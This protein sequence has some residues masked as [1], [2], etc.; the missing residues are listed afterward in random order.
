MVSR[1][2]WCWISQEVIT[3]HSSSVD[4][5]A[6]EHDG[7]LENGAFKDAFLVDEWKKP[8]Y[9]SIIGKR[10]VYVS[11]GG[12][13]MEMKNNEGDLMDTGEPSHLQGRHEEADTVIA[14]Y[15]SSVFSREHSGEVHRHGRPRH[16]GEVHRHGR[17][18]HSPWVFRK[19]RKKR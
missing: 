7:A 10:T 18:P 12:K 17:P 16:S 9:R 15:G 4:I 1:S 5:Q 2:A 13:C 3:T 6:A 14:L 19:I 8:H 11:H